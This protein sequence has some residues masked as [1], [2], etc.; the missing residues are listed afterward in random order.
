MLG[1]CQCPMQVPGTGGTQQ[2]LWNGRKIIQVAFLYHSVHSVSFSHHPEADQFICLYQE[3]IS[4]QNHLPMV[5]SMLPLENVKASQI[6]SVIQPSRVENAPSPA[7][8]LQCSSQTRAP[9]Y[10]SQASVLFISFRASHSRPI[11]RASPFQLL[12][13]WNHSSSFHRLNWL[14]VYALEADCLGLKTKS[15]T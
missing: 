8:F 10:L 12:D 4:L 1:D 7:S 14:R 11:N 13:P 5:F 2:W 9:V 3:W 15:T 6:Y